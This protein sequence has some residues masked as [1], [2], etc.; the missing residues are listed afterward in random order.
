V[1]DEM[2]LT[3]GKKM[4]VLL[5]TELMHGYWLLGEVAKALA[6]TKQCNIWDSN[7]RLW[8]RGDELCRQ[9]VDQEFLPST[10]EL[11]LVI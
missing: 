1:K 8:C 10:R 9:M 6:T 11:N 2:L 5:A 4:D 3:A 7:Q